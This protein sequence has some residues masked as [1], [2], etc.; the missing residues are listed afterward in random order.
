MERENAQIYG[1][2]T[3]LIHLHASVHEKRNPN[4]VFTT[5]Q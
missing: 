3:V 5:T 2:G 1:E 4:A